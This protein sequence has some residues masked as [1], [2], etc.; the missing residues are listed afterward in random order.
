MRCPYCDSADTVERRCW[1][2]EEQKTRLSS[3]VNFE[4]TAALEVFQNKITL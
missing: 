4:V 2:A 3:A 1:G